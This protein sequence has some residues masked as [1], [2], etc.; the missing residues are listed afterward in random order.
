MNPSWTDVLQGIG[1]LASAIISLFGFAF[2]YWQI[3]QTNDGIEKQNHASIYNMGFELFKIFVEHQ[4]LR[5][6]FYDGKNLEK[7]DDNFQKVMAIAELHADFFEYIILEQY[8]ID[9]EMKLTMIK[10]MKRLF[11]SSD[12]LRKFLTEYSDCYNSEFLHVI[13]HTSHLI[14]NQKN[15]K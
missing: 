1:T 8:S 4:E 15:I 12:A 14:N 6:Y 11:K 13:G 10:Y 9:R 3:R 7:N 5:P 2:I